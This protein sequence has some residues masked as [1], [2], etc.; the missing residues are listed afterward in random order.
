[1]WHI[2]GP[3]GDV[4][5]L[6]LE[7]PDR[8]IYR[9]TCRDGEK[10]FDESVYRVSYV[11]HDKTWRVRREGKEERKMAREREGRACTWNNTCE[12]Q[13]TTSKL[14][15]VGMGCVVRDLGRQKS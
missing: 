2:E 5:E 8:G 10:H 4:D 3:A 6:R 9:K 13:E 11:Y 7:T 15:V 1:M 12:K 14:R